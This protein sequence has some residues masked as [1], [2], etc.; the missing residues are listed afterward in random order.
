MLMKTPH[1]EWLLSGLELQALLCFRQ[2]M[3]TVE[4]AKALMLRGGEPEAVRLLASA[5][6]KIRTAR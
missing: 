4:I 1:P 2:S 5:R 6:E 3:N